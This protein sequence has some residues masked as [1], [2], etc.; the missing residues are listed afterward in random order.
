MPKNEMPKAYEPMQYE[1]AIYAAWEQ[2]GLF[3]PDHLPGERT[4]TFSMVLPPPNVT[5][6]LHLGHAVMLAIEDIMVRFA[7]MRG[8]KTLWLPGTDHAAIAT[9][10]KVEGILRKETG[11]SRHDF[12]REAF[13]D[14]VKKFAANSHDT[15]V[16]QCRKMGA[17]L[18]W[19]REAYTLDAARNRAVNT[20]F[21][22]MYDD[23]LIYR[24]NRVV[25][26]D[27]VGQTVIADDEIVHKEVQAAF[28]TFRYG[29][30]FPIAISTTRPETKVGDTAVAVHPGDER[31]AKFVGKTIDVSFAGVELKIKIVA[32]ISVDPAFGTGALGVAP[33]HS[34]IGSEIAA[35]HQLPMV[36][37]IG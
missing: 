21:K 23:G 36:Q 12:G 17:S 7:R 16:G 6:T 5:G 28:F 9:Q 37:V 34:V 26:W 4:E 3:N 24:G 11:K 30:D 22:M 18:D 14:E 33:A 20:M 19:S 32:D 10:S 29:K 31:Y 13:L 1:D 15:I 8:K 25:N 27:P 2:S 35:C